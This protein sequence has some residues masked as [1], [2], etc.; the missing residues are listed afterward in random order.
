MIVIGMAGQTIVD[1]VVV[2]FRSGMDMAD[3]SE[4]GRP[5]QSSR[6]YRNR[7]TGLVIPKEIGAAKPAEA[8]LYAR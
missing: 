2:T 1:L 8:A 3:Q 6:H 5:I 4:V 7:W